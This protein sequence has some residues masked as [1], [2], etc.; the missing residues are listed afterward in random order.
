MSRNEPKLQNT[1]YYFLIGCHSKTDT[2]YDF[3]WTVS[4]YIMLFQQREEREGRYKR[5]QGGQEIVIRMLTR[6]FLSKYLQLLFSL[7]LIWY[8]IDSTNCKKKVLQAQYISQIREQ[9]CLERHFQYKNSILGRFGQSG[10]Q[11]KKI[12]TAISMLLLRPVFFMFSWGKNNFD[13]FKNT[14]ASALKSYMI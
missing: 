12:Q 6:F 13:F 7:W 3:F 2:L 10:L 9:M 5:L 1:K 8:L 4:T 14:L 11:R